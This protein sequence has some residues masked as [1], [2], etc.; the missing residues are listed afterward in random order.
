[1]SRKNK[2]YGSLIAKVGIG[3]DAVLDTIIK[4]DSSTTYDDLSR[5]PPYDIKKTADK[6]YEIKLALAGAKKETIIAAVDA[7][8]LT[9]NATVDKAYDPEGD[10]VYFHQG[11]FEGGEF[12]ATFLLAKNLQVASAAFVD[13][14]LTIKFIDTNVTRSVSNIPIG[15]F[16]A[17]LTD[18][19]FTIEYN[20]A[21]SPVYVPVGVSVESPSAISVLPDAV[22][23]TDLPITTT[24]STTTV[25]VNAGSLSA[26]TTDVVLPIEVPSVVSVDLTNVTPN[27][28]TASSAPQATITVND[29][30]HEIVAGA[31]LV[32]I[33]T[34]DPAVA[35]IVVAIPSEVK[36]AADSV[37][38]D[39]VADVTAALD[40]A[41][42][43]ENIVPAPATDVVIPSIQEVPVLV[44]DAKTDE[45][46]VEVLVP[47]ELPSVVE[48][49]KNPD[50][51]KTDDVPS[52][53]LDT[54]VGSDI[55]ADSILIPVVTPVGQ[56]DIVVAVA[57]ELHKELT[58]GGV[59]IARDVAKALEV[60][61][62]DVVSTPVEVTSVVNNS[63]D[64]TVPT[65]GVDVPKE[66]PQVVE[67]TAVSVP[68]IDADSP[69]VQVVLT[70]NDATTEIKSDNVV[71]DVI[72]TAPDTP[73]VV[74]AIDQTLHDDLK[75]K[76][77]DAIQ[78]VKD[79]IGDAMP[80]MP[81]APLI[82]APKDIEVLVKPVDAA[83][84]DTPVTVVVPDVIPQVVEAKV[85]DDKVVL[86]DVALNIPVDAT[87]TPV[88]TAEGQPDIVVVTT[89]ATDAA[90]EVKGLDVAT[91]IAAAVVKAD[92]T[93]VQAGDIVA[94]APEVTSVVVDQT[95]TTTPS[96]KV[97]MPTD[98]PQIVEATL[99]DVAP[100]IDTVSSE[101]QATVVLT[102]AMHEVTDNAVLTPVATDS[103][104]ADVIVSVAPEVQKAAD[105]AGVDIMDAVTKALDKADVTLPDAP[106]A[107][108]VTDVTQS[109][110][111]V[112][113]DAT[114]AADVVTVTVPDVV[115][116]VMKAEVVGNTVT[117]T[118]TDAS[119][120]PDA[121]LVAVVT[122]GVQP[123]I[124]VS[125]P[126]DVAA[127][128]TDAGLEVAPVLADVL[129]Q[130]D[131]TVSVETTPVLVE[132]S[133][134][135]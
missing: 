119:V 11:I 65:V 90:L 135:P 44:H 59:D 98:V 58:D 125:V 12:K 131:V 1:M 97:T 106:V 22:P 70:V 78:E 23:V 87:L 20:S 55:P 101:P 80:K 71:T 103:G 38:I 111:A 21:G 85:V 116:P 94:A 46:K 77:I 10:D 62:P 79:A 76:G 32:V 67:I 99:V 68:H 69:D 134:T 75:A 36:A 14:L 33:K 48:L 19:Q 112:T 64:V 86:S 30:T 95:D 51:P 2:S 114:P 57:P 34:P 92:P 35:D 128:I 127:T 24:D 5:C 83:P 91:D 60:A 105:V 53:V 17:E 96:V 113:P 8:F 37:G 49:V 7:E 126:A 26:P 25:T 40:A 82:E 42:K 132:A 129:K 31:E 15:P 107:P 124:V 93:V 6:T 16:P 63:D 28:D 118:P 133:M 88:V 29:A 100:K 123:D 73:D 45:P 9:V 52:V 81:E 102:D 120:A 3:Y 72:K 121:T 117:L 56:S 89:P 61:K 84:S 18:K 50:A 130:A 4:V 109:S 122:P 54:A 108:V 115:T 13:S 27:M 47:S 43:S 110:V 39:V 41:T 104:K 66:L 74:I